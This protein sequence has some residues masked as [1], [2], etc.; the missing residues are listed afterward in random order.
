[1]CIRD[2]ST[3]EQGGSMMY[4]QP[5]QYQQPMQQPMAQQSFIVVYPQGIAWRSAPNYNARVTNVQGPVLNTVLSGPVVQGQDGLQYLQ[6]GSYFVPMTSQQGQQLIVPQQMQ[7]ALQ[8]DVYRVQQTY[9]Q[10]Q[11]G[12]APHQGYGGGHHHMDKKAM[13][14]QY[15]GHKNKH[16]GY[17]IKL[18]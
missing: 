18:F 17:K 16:K 12:Y 11:P 3:G 10:P 5:T 9:H 13:K 15:K 2:R 4:Q 6:V 7:Q 1:M 8:Q 14:K